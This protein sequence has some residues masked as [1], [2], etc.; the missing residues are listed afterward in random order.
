[1]VSE[2]IICAQQFRGIRMK[3][4]DT[5]RDL[6]SSSL[7]DVVAFE[8]VLIMRS[9]KTVDT[10]N[11]MVHDLNMATSKAIRVL[12]EHLNQRNIPREY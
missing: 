10:K 5:T 11:K 3:R 8:Q 4:A 9:D 2:S 1:M 12:T 6:I 7:R